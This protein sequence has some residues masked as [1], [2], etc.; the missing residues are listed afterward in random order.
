VKAVG[1]ELVIAHPNDELPAPELA[2]VVAGPAIYLLAN[3]ALRLRLAGTISRR[4]LAGATARLAVAAVGSFAPAWLV[5]A[6]VGRRPRRRGRRRAARPARR[7]ARGEPS[8]IEG[9]A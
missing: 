3:V 8:A 2:A 5:A 4:R 9:I 7:I 6:L 1:D